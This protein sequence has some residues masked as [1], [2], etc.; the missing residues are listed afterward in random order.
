MTILNNFTVQNNGSCV[1]QST[2]GQWIGRK[3][4]EYPPF[5]GGVAA[6]QNP[7]MFMNGASDKIAEEAVKLAR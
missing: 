3:W 4:G 1:A 5:G 7:T 6:A 2:F